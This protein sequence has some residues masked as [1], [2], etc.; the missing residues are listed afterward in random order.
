[1]TG[2]RLPKIRKNAASL[3][4]LKAFGSIFI[5]ISRH[6]NGISSTKR[7]M[8]ADSASSTKRVSRFGL[9]TYIRG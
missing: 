6:G 4:R 2:L 3:N 5:R 8:E 9:P 1:V 7:L